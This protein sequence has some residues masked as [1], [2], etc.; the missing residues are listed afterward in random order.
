MPILRSSAIVGLRFPPGKHNTRSREIS[1]ATGG[2]RDRALE[3]EPVQNRIFDHPAFAKNPYGWTDNVPTKQTSGSPFSSALRLRLVLPSSIFS[4]RQD[5]AGSGGC[6]ALPNACA[7]LPSVRTRSPPATC[8]RSAHDLPKS[9]G[10]ASPLMPKRWPANIK[11][12]KFI[13]PWHRALAGPLRAI[14]DISKFF[15]VVY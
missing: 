10:H 13:P 7:I 11:N 9:A 12:G 8:P 15:A 6:P 3:I 14:V 1:A 5:Q 4:S 2:N